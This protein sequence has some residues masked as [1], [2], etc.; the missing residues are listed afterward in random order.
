MDALVPKPVPQFAG[1]N[2]VTMA[3]HVIAGPSC[4]VVVDKQAMFWM[5]GK[6]K[7]TGDGAPSMR[8]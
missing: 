4:S 5:A 6:W 8:T 1:P 3:A 2:D 7:N